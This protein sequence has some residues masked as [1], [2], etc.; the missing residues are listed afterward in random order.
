MNNKTGQSAGIARINTLS[1]RNT[2]IDIAE[3]LLREVS[4]NADNSKFAL[5]VLSRM[6]ASQIE[7]SEHD[8]N[9]PDPYTQ[10]DIKGYF[11]LVG[12]KAEKTRPEHIEEYLDIKRNIRREREAKGNKAELSETPNPRF[13]QLLGRV[14]AGDGRQRLDYIIDELRGRYEILLEEMPDHLPGEENGDGGNSRFYI[15]KINENDPIIKASKALLINFPILQRIKLR[16]YDDIIDAIKIDALMD[17]LSQE[18]RRQIRDNI[19]SRLTRDVLGNGDREG[20]GQPEHASQKLSASELLFRARTAYIIE[21]GIRRQTPGFSMKHFSDSDYETTVLNAVSGIMEINS[22]TF[23][24]PDDHRSYDMM[25]HHI[26]QSHYNDAKMYRGLREVGRQNRRI[27]DD[28]RD[29][30]SRYY[31]YE[32][33]V[34][35]MMNLVAE[36]MTGTQLL[37]LRR[38]IDHVSEKKKNDSLESWK[39]VFSMFANEIHGLDEIGFVLLAESARMK[40]DYYY[41]EGDDKYENPLVRGI[42][43]PGFCQGFDSDEIGY[44]SHIRSRELSVPVKGFNSLFQALLAA[45]MNNKVLPDIEEY[46]HYPAGYFNQWLNPIKFEASYSIKDRAI[47]AELLNN[48]PIFSMIPVI[49]RN[50]IFNGIMLH[51][52]QRHTGN[53]HVDTSATITQNLAIRQIYGL[54]TFAN[55]GRR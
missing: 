47:A 10:E 55:G 2:T 20:H 36:S 12:T 53:Y 51:M 44:T 15:D 26:Y 24:N 38:L 54:N 19:E 39:E 41:A 7:D 29:S 16:D 34:G 28:E 9:M 6:Y 25:M 48:Y 42:K 5:Y 18:Y 11:L 50:D 27:R 4:D 8:S 14:I 33:H 30:F 3:I 21:R 23:R 52:L 32:E 37:M 22:N 45:H 31:Q 49:G 1:T 17:D 13:K 46:D 40:V 35:K 43:L